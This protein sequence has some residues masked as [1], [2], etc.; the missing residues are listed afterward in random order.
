MF[1]KIALKVN[2]QHNTQSGI[3][4]LYSITVFLILFSPQNQN[5]NQFIPKD[6]RF[7]VHIY[8]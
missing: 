5:I 8:V 1:R 3:C 4:I 6:I 2:K 7:V